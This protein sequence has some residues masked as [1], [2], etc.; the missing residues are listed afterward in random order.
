[1]SKRVVIVTGSARGIGEAIA[2]RFG[3]A[4]VAVV[5]NA[6][7]ADG[8]GPEVAA[9]LPEARFVAADVADPSDCSRVGRRGDLDLGAP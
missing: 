9:S 1:M 6:R 2:R 5:V 7:S 3:A 4:G 8:P